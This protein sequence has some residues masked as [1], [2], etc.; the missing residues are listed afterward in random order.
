MSKLCGGGAVSPVAEN[1]QVCEMGS[2]CFDRGHRAGELPEDV[3]ETGETIWV[4]H[5]QYMENGKMLKPISIIF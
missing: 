2:A 4:L 1:R 3:R 5:K